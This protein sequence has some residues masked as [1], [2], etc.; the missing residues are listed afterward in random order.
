MVEYRGGGGHMN[1]V[2]GRKVL[3]LIT[4]SALLFA[5]FGCN[6]RKNARDEFLKPQEISGCASIFINEGAWPVEG[7]AQA[8]S[9]NTDS[10]FDYPDS[11]NAYSEELMIGQ[12]APKIAGSIDIYISVY[13]SE[14]KNLTPPDTHGV[15]QLNINSVSGIPVSSAYY[16]SSSPGVIMLSI[17]ACDPRREIQVFCR[18]ASDRSIEEYLDVVNR[19]LGSMQLDFDG[20]I[21]LQ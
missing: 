4:C 5:T 8:V 14:H 17:L 16:Y 18:L 9:G 10:S 7:Y 6:T 12:K 11:W 20:I 13:S 2:I 3:A 15:E 1:T 21:E 19:I